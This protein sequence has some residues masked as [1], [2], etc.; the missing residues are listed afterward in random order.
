MAGNYAPN[1]YGGGGGGGGGGLVVDGEIV[2]PL[3]IG[4]DYVADNGREFVFTVPQSSGAS[5]S[6]KCY[7]SGRHR[8]RLGMTWLV[9]GAVALEAPSSLTLTFNLPGSATAALI[10]G[11]YLYSVMIV[12]DNGNNITPV[13]SIDLPLTLIYGQGATSDPLPC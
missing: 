2:S 9:E 1:Y 10:P 5:A 6:S 4:D 3:I 11:E 8:Y 13:A 12:D 7:F